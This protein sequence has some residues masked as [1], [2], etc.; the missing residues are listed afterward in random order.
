MFYREFLKIT[1]VLDECFVDAFDFWLATLSDRDAKTISVS[2]VASRLEVKY[3]IADAI[4]R[5]AEKEGILKKR[6]IVLCTNEEC[7]FFYGEF[8]ADELRSIL[9]TVGYCHNCVKEFNI[10]YE[11]TQV[12]YERIKNP[13]VPESVIEE[14][15]KKRE[16]K[17]NGDINFLLA[18]TL[19]KN[20]KEIFELYYLPSESAYK[21]LSELKLALNG[22]FRTSKE[23]GDALEKLALC[24]FKQI[25][26]VSGTNKIRTNTNQF[27]CTIRFPQSSEAF[28]TIMKY[29]TP[30]FI[31]ECKNEMKKSGK[32][33]TPSNTYFHKLSD[34][35]SAN[36]AKLGIVM[37]RGEASAEDI[38]IAYHN[39]LV[40]K[41]TKQPKVMLSFSDIDLEALIDRRV[42]LLEYL[43]YKMDALTMNAKN[44]TFEMFETADL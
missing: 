35:M 34:I 31:I 28:P 37:S 20:P 6:Y 14:A 27:D 11:N 42:N 15:I 33:K 10:S 4:M 36:E 2:T 29:M 30:Y 32:G 9:G 40:C 12:V 13:N 1:E 3:S 22:P 18:D 38:G 41:S 19:A 17:L 7:E 16:E 39:Y 43:S 25:K 5:F 8:E 23:Q 21:E 24:L 44:A 26:A